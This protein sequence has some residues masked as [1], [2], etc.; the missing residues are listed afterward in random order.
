MP[1]D[2]QLL[3]VCY[4]FEVSDAM[5][6]FLL[7]TIL[8]SG[9]LA[10]DDSPCRPNFLVILCEDLD[11]GEHFN[12]RGGWN[13]THESAWFLQ[14]TRTMLVMERGRQLWLAPFVTN[15]WLED[16]MFV[17]VRNAPTHFG[18]VGYKISS[19]IKRGF[20][21]AVIDPPTRNPPEQLVIRVRHPEDRP[22]RSVTI[23]GKS[24]QDFNTVKETIT[25]KP[26]SDWIVLRIDYDLGQ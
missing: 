2:I 14:M 26:T 10:V 8:A 22:M 5:S 9:V 23:N 17:S 6:I 7:F 13:K 25:I 16:G 4:D 18:K 20:I 3:P 11:Y 15:N 19:S 12:R 24:H 1:V 21:E